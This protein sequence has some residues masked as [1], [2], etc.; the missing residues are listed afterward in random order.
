MI[1]SPFIILFLHLNL[2][3]WCN[4]KNSFSSSVLYLSLSFIYCKVVYSVINGIKL[5]FLFNWN[6]LFNWLKRYTNI[7]VVLSRGTNLLVKGEPTPRDIITTPHD[8]I[9]TPRDVITTT[10][11]V[12]TTPRDVIITPRDVTFY[13]L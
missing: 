3:H 10:R 2:K 8:V 12:I 13:Y 1:Y 9:T 7:F 5:K 6:F 4:L 11:D